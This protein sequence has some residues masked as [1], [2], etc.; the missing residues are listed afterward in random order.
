MDQTVH[1]LLRFDR[2]V[3]D[4]TRGCL[5]T[6]DRD[7]DLR[8]KTFRVLRH[9]AEN[10]GRL[11]PKRELYEI[12]WPNIVVTDDSLVQCVRELRQA[13]GDDKYCLI[14]T[15]SRRGYLLDVAVSSSDILAAPVSPA[16]ATTTASLVP[17]GHPITEDENIDRDALAGERKHATVLHADL[18]ESLE[19]IAD[20]DPAKALIIFDGS[21]K[22][23]RQAAQRYDGTVI[24]ETADGIVAL[25]GVPFAQEDH[26]VRACYAA[27]QMQESVKPFAQELLR[28]TPVPI[29]VRV[30]VNSGEVIVRSTKTSLHTH[31]RT[32]GQTTRFATHLGQI[33]APG[34]T[35]VSAATLRLAE[36]HIEVKLIEGAS[37]SPQG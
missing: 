11:V 37:A 27:L 24:Q 1:R 10:A 3:L 23:M 29:T 31:Y 12:V 19:L 33:A 18:K 5:R 7:I 35:L 4:L 20:D 15:V 16:V 21:L 2:F 28:S 13:L 30:G 26:A 6:G 9:L 17:S 34:K 14:K 36:G 8:P 32:M 22:L 25:F